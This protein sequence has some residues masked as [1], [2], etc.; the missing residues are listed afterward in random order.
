MNLLKETL[1][2]LEEHGRNEDEV[3]WVGSNDFYTT[4][5]HF[6]TIA[7]VEYDEGYGSPRIAVDLKVVGGHWW[8]ERHEY[9]GSEWW[10]YKT[11][12]YKP[13]ERKDF[14]KVDGG[15]WDTLIELNTEQEDE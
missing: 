10:E 14:R 9:D 5:E 3:V 12:P 1:E 15:M 6:K 8:L 4:W 7:N 11:L 2:I 13:S